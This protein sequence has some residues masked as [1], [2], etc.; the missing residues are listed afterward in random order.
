MNWV[1]QYG[2]EWTC[3][4]RLK[5]KRTLAMSI[6]LPADGYWLIEICEDGKFCVSGTDEKFPTLADAKS[7]CE[8]IEQ[9]LGAACYAANVG[10]Y[11]LATKYGDGDPY[12]HF[13]VGFVSGYTRHGRYLI[14][15]NEGATQRLNGF[16]RVEK[17]T[18]DEGRKMVERMPEIVDKPGVSVWWHLADIRGVG[19]DRFCEQCG[20]E[21][22]GCCRCED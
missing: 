1:F 14:M 8:S 16:C 3:T 21:K 13:Y 2:R 11:V 22:D 12:D 4:S 19:K 6:L 15:N 18:A 17:I 10:D 20:Y 7:F 5:S 9:G